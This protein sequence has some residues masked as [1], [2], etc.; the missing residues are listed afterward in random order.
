MFF[1]VFGIVYLA[2]ISGNLLLVVL[3]STQRGLQTPMY[4]FLVN[5]SCLEV[6]YTSNIVPMMLVDL[7]RNNRVISMAGCV[8]QLCFS[9]AL[10]STE[11]CLLA[12]TSY[13][14]YLAICQPL[15]DPTLMHGT[16][17]VGLVIG[18]WVSGFTVA[19][20]FQAAMVPS[21][22]FC[23]GNEINHFFCD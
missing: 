2:T 14:C 10:G 4:F 1:L 3:V 19:A 11:C 15:H 6:C 20:A 21:L 8:M 23:D 18:S 17:C 9:G 12:A 7:L 22:T 5:L 16:I 13:D